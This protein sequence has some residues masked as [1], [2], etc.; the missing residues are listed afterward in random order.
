MASL[1]KFDPALTGSDFCEFSFQLKKNPGF[2]PD[3]YSDLS[4]MLAKYEQAMSDCC[5]PWAMLD[6]RGKLGGVFWVG[7]IE[8]AHQA[9]LYIWIWSPACYTATT[10]RAMA[11]Y[12]SECA[13]SNQ[14][15]RLVCRTWDDL[16]LGRLLERLGFRLE[17]RFSR[18]YKSGGQA[19]T[20]YQYRKIFR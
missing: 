12:I 20:L 3:I 15:D 13:K 18:G 1:R 11:G 2:L 7:D 4:R 8:I 14:L 6:S 5:Q 10:C 16:R 17:G 19:R 9:C